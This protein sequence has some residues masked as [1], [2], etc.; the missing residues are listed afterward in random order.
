MDVA[1]LEKLPTA[2]DGGSRI[3]GSEENR[4]I[5][6]ANQQYLCYCPAL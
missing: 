2:A 3:A 4:K 1:E 5:Q 6:E